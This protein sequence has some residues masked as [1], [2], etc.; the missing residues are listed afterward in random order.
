MIES[1]T[2]WTYGTDGFLV[3]SEAFENVREVSGV[4][5]LDANM[6]SIVSEFNLCPIYVNIGY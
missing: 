3:S 2:S 6:L 4:A 5:A 1:K